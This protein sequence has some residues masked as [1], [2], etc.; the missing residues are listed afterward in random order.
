MTDF[1]YDLA[2]NWITCPRCNGTREDPKGLDAECYADVGGCDGVG[3]VRKG[4]SK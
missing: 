4:V 1:E 2:N 3:R